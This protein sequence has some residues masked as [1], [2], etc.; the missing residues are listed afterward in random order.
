[1]SIRLVSWNVNGLRAVSAKPEWR[2]FAENTC[3]VIGLQ[4]T[5]AMPE[6]L[7]PE[8]ASP[9]GWE[10]HWASSVVKKGYSGVAVFSRIKP[11]AVQRIFYGYGV[12]SLDTSAIT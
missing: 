2:W 4:E 7:R 10:A 11:L 9:A 12:Q 1:M 5:K 8:V 3:D 6:Q